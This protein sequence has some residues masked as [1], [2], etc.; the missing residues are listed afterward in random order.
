MVDDVYYLARASDRQRQTIIDIF[1]AGVNRYTECLFHPD[2]RM[3][4]TGR[5]GSMLGRLDSRLSDLPALGRWI[6]RQRSCETRKTK[7]VR[8]LT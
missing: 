3:T 8:C 1:G 2:L 4:M 6:A 7:N 5:D